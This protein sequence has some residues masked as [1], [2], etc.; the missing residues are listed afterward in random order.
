M[1]AGV[2]ATQNATDYGSKAPPT[3]TSVRRLT[4]CH[5]TTSS[6]IF[7][8]MATNVMLTKNRV[9]VR[10]SKVDAGGQGRAFS[11]K[12]FV[13]RLSRAFS[14]CLFEECGVRKKWQGRE[15]VC[16]CRVSHLFEVCVFFHGG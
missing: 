16:V 5:K 15:S 14:A 1:R 3:R 2:S 4:S 12:C 10:F 8:A 7:V 13:Q 9:T 11:Q 6:V